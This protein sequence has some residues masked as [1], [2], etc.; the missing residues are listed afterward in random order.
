MRVFKTIRRLVMLNKEHKVDS[1]DQCL[2]D[3]IVNILDDVHCE[4]VGGM[5]CWIAGGRYNQCYG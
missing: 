2:F 1:N 4:F 5:H 3:G